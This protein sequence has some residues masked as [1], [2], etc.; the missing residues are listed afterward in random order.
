MKLSKIVT[1]SSNTNAAKE[2]KE[3]RA[4]VQKFIDSYDD[5]PAGSTGREWLPALQ[6]L[7]KYVRPYRQGD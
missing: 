4:A 3:L 2:L 7:R 6:A 1:E 5:R